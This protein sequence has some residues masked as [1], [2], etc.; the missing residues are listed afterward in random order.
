MGFRNEK[1]NNKKSS[2]DLSDI[3]KK[4]KD[5]GFIKEGEDY[6]VNLKQEILQREKEE[7][8]RL[9]KEL[10]KM[11]RRKFQNNQEFIDFLNKLIA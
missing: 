6:F 3:L 5:R 2:S 9:E 10:E 4:L 1:G 11:T 7:I 8:K